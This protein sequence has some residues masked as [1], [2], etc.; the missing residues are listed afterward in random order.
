[1]LTTDAQQR[2]AGDNNLQSGRAGN[3][4]LDRLSGDDYLFEIVEHQ[5][6]LLRLQMLDERV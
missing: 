5:Q 6:Q 2:A 3:K 4:L 1:M